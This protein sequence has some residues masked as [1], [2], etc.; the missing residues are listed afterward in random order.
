MG[1][2]AKQAGVYIHIPFC[3][4]KCRYCDFY[5]V[6]YSDEH[7]LNDYSKAVIYEIRAAS[8]QLHNILVTTVFF[9]GGTPSLL[10]A[11]NIEGI[12]DT[13]K[14][15]FPI[16]PTAEITVEANPA[17]IDAPKMDQYLEAGVNRFSVGAQSFSDH[18]LSVL[19]RIHKSDDILRIV[20]LFHRKNIRNFNLDLIYGIPGQSVKSWEANL[21][22]AIDCTPAHISAYL[23]QLGPETVMAKMAAQNIIEL[24]DENTEA[25]MYERTIDVLTG[26]GFRHYELSNFSR[27][28]FECQ[29]NLIYWR[30]ENYLGFGA[31]AVSYIDNRR[32]INRPQLVDYIKNLTS[33]KKQAIEELENMTMKEQVS[34]I[35][36]L[37]L[38]LC[39]GININ[40]INQR[41]SINIEKEY[42]KA[43]D[44][45]IQKG[46]LN[47]KNGQLFLTRRGYFLSN[48]V[49]CHFIA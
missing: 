39:E 37:G 22:K 11:R 49:L 7:L 13:I 44:D 26:C 32:F 14:D 18:E 41:F 38:R 31:G 1:I 2:E 9:G 33:G 19:G 25:V 36:I 47:Y 12:L 17:T 46:L 16:S 15:S 35:I 45:N 8:E 40:E 21:T 5:S 43:I 4:N 20:E 30:G 29:H 48:E 24:C 10:T 28:E 27:P 3:Q 42:G 6:D 34:D 23:L